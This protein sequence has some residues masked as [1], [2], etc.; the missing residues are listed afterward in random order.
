MRAQRCEHGQI[1]QCIKCAQARIEASMAEYRRRELIDARTRYEKRMNNAGGADGTKH[2]LTCWAL[3]GHEDCEVYCRNGH[4]RTHETSY[5]ST[6]RRGR[7]I[8]VCKVC[9][10][11]Q[12]QRRYERE[13]SKS[14]FPSWEARRAAGFNN[15]SLEA[16]SYYTER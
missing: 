10:S 7:T 12:R 11:E 3:P 9:V 15:A 1:G 2:S 16:P 8:N 4:R 14:E 13:R 5:L 6:N